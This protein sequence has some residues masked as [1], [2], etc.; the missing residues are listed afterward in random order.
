MNVP[1][2]PMK[3]SAR[4]NNPIGTRLTAETS[5]RKVGGTNGGG[6]VKVG[7]RVGVT[8]A[9]NAASSVGSIV[10]VES[11]VG[12]AGAGITGKGP[13]CLMFTYGPYTQAT[14]PGTPG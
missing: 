8:G 6:G 9:M 12:V 11:G 5:G 7:R 13:L 14:D 1:K 10:G 3:P 2:T 4:I